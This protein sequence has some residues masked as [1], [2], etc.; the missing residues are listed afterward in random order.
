[1]KH[2]RNWLVF[3][4]LSL[5]ALPMTPVWWWLCAGSTRT[6]Y[7]HNCWVKTGS[8]TIFGAIAMLVLW[9]VWGLLFFERPSN[10]PIGLGLLFLLL[11]IVGNVLTL[12]G[13][14]VVAIQLHRKS[15]DI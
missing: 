4:L 7:W 1:M 3:F 2:S 5:T 11:A 6:I 10:N 9:P 13:D 15:Q 12:I 8:L 14:I